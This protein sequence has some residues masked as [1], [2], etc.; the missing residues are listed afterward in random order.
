MT[1]LIESM[2]LILAVGFY[3]GKCNI[4]IKL[5]QC[6]ANNMYKWLNESLVCYVKLHLY[7]EDTEI[8]IEL[9]RS[10]DIYE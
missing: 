10:E 6:Y 4:S 8:V 2:K 1:L 5:I 9:I 7:I 3:I